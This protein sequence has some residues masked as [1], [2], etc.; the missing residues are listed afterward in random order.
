MENKEN[1]ESLISSFY[2]PKLPSFS[3]RIAAYILDFICV[4]IVCVGLCL[5]FSFLF[6][7]D[8][9]NDALNL[10]YVEYG[11]KY[12]DE[13]NNLLIKEGTTEELSALWELFDQDEK[14][15][16]L[17]N[18]VVDLSLIIPIL[19]VSISIFIFEFIVPLFMKHGR[20][21]GR[22]AFK[23]ALITN[24]GIEVKMIH[25]FIR[26]LFGK[27]MI[28]ALIPL[29][30]IL[31][32]LL[33]MANPFIVIMLLG[34]WIINLILIIKSKNHIGISDFLA[35]VYPCE[36]EGQTFFDSVEELNAKKEE[37]VNRYH[38]KKVY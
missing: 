25:L 6:G 13:E 4:A 33:N 22:Y 21:I 32:V 10:K 36:I 18:K 24:E 20:S 9:A 11:L 27:L 14:A 35:K 17:W 29:I 1:I 34:I 8:K 37:E 23:I 7:Y 38:R 28:T 30:C 12:Y 19:S 3:K 15:I 31:S 2:K 16:Q 26:F 5:L